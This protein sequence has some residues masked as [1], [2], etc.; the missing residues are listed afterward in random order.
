MYEILYT[1]FC[2]D[3]KLDCLSDGFNRLFFLSWRS[4]ARIQHDSE[5]FFELVHLLNFKDPAVA[6]PDKLGELTALRDP[7]LN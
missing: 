3:S 6:N 2:H 5:R 1:I 4:G 7:K